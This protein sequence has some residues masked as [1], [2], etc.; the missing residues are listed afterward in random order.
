MAFRFGG[1]SEE[2]KRINAHVTFTVGNPSHAW[3]ACTPPGFPYENVLVDIAAWWSE[4]DPR[5]GAGSLPS[6]LPAAAQPRRSPPYSHP[7]TA[8]HTHTW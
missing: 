2:D 3:F 5:G 6:H 7:G 4:R 8:L 1:W